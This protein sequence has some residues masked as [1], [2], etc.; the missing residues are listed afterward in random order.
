MSKVLTL[1][2]GGIGDILTGISCA[3]ILKQKGIPVEI[4]LCARDEVAEIVI[5]CFGGIFQNLRQHH[6]KSKWGDDNWILNNLDELKPLREKYKEIYYITP[7]LLFRNP[8]AFDFKKYDVS[9]QTLTTQKLLAPSWKPTKSI[10]VGLISST[11][12]YTYRNI[13]ELVFQLGLTFPNHTIHCPIVSK[14]AGHDIFMGKFDHGYTENVKLYRDPDFKSQLDIMRTC[15]YAIVGDN[16]P[17]HVLYSLGCPRLLLDP[18]F[19]FTPESL[20]WVA[21]WRETIS[22]SIPIEVNVEDIVEIVKANIL[23]P[24]TQLIPRFSMLINKGSLW[25]KALLFKY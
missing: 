2:S 18:R 22:D 12:G 5:Y 3:Y 15:E 16:G 1:L 11:P 14:W 24:Q 8:L 21:R 17:S 9:L 13:P 10:Y 23:I 25:E 7:D 20:A 19:F 6:L 4:L